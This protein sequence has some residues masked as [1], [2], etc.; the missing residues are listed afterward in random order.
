MDVTVQYPGGE[1]ARGMIRELVP[2]R[3]VVFGWGYE[4]GLHGWRPTH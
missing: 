2:D 3:K 4:K 1:V